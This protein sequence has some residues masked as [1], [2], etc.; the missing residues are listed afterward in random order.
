M[1]LFYKD[2][3]NGARSFPPPFHG[4]HEKGSGTKGKARKRNDRGTLNTNRIL[5]GGGD[6]VQNNKRVKVLG[7]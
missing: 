5:K 1:R 4:L 2:R 7:L 3:K 6:V